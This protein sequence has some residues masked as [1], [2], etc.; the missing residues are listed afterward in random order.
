MIGKTYKVLVDGM[1]DMK[2]V[3]KW[4]GRTPCNRLVHFLPSTSENNANEENLT[5]NWVDVKITS[6]TALSCQ[7]DLVSVYGKNTPNTHHHPR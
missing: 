5:W 1:S 4:K 7:G 2:G 3:K 6:A